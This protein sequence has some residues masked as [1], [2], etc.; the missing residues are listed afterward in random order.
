MTQEQR[1]MKVSE[2]AYFIVVSGHVSNQ[3]ILPYSPQLAN[4]CI[5]YGWEDEELVAPPADD[6]P[7]SS[8]DTPAD[9]WGV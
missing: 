3:G 8:E 2:D 5:E 7:A 9:H 4:Q 1:L 6:Q